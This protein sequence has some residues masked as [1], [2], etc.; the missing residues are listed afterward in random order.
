MSWSAFEY[1]YQKASEF[2]D[3]LE[4]EIENNDRVND[5][6][7]CPGYSKET[8]SELRKI[9]SNA[10]KLAKLMKETEWLYSGDNSEDTFLRNITK[11]KLTRRSI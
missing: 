8:I 4:C 10:R 6:G 1:L 5:L 11:I 2:A 7:Y 3:K 9:E